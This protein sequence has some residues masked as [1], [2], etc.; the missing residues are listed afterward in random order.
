MDVNKTLEERG[1][2]Y[3]DFTGHAKV[4]QQIQDIIIEQFNEAHSYEW[5]ALPDDI[6]EAMF[7]IAHKIGRIANGDPYYDDSWRDIAGYATLVA[8]RLTEESL[9]QE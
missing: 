6:K 2:R 1:K 3:G 9:R 5:V 4:S 7:M 8:N